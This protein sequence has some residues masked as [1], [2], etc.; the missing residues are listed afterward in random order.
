MDKN[1]NIVKHIYYGRVL[2]GVNIEKS[3]WFPY[4]IF[5]FDTIT[6]FDKN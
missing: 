6:K 3:I 4:C 5:Y 1:K 2:E